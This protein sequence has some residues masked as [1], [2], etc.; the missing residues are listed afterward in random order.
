MILLA[1]ILVSGDMRFSKLMVRICFK[2]KVA[3][4]AM[5]EAEV[6]FFHESIVKR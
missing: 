4:E 2:I 3:V 1:S 5:V 6:K